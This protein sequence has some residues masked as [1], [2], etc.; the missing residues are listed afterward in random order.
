MLFNP[1]YAKNYAGIIDTGL[2]LSMNAP[3]CIQSSLLAVKQRLPGYKVSHDH[4][5]ILST[6][7]TT[8]YAILSIS[9]SII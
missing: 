6:D 9:G 4:V 7:L 1:Y 5:V 2:G 3:V 8:F